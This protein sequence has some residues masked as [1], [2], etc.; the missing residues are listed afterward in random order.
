L[1]KQYCSLFSKDSNTNIPC[2]GPSTAP[3]LPNITMT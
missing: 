3:P 1:N 2:K